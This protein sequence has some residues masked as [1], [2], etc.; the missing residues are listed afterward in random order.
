MK[1][2]LSFLL[3][4]V[5]IFSVLSPTTVLAENGPHPVPDGGWDTSSGVADTENYS[6]ILLF[7]SEGDI[8]SSLYPEDEEFP[9]DDSIKDNI[10]YDLS[11]NTLYLNGL[12]GKDFSLYLYDMGDDFKID[13]TGYNELLNISALNN[14]RGSSVA[15][16]G[17]G[18]L[19]LNRSGES[20][21][22][23]IAIV[24]NGS[25]DV[26]SIGESVKF[27]A[28]PYDDGEWQI[29]SV[30][31]I[32][33]T[34]ASPIVVNGEIT[35][36]EITEDKYVYD[37][38]KQYTV[39]DVANSAVNYY[40]AA[41][42]DEQDSKYDLYIAYEDYEN[43]GYVLYSIKYN[44]QIDLF[45]A[46]EYNEGNP[47]NPAE[48]GFTPAASLPLID[49]ETGFYVGN[50]E[51]YTDFDESVIIKDIFFDDSP[52]L[53]DICVDESGKE[54][55]YIAT[56]SFS[57][58]EANPVIRYTVYDLIQTEEFGFVARENPDIVS[59]EGF[60][61]VILNS[62]GRTD[63]YFSSESAINNGGN[64]TEPGVVKKITLTNN[65]DSIDVSFPAVKNAEY[66]D[67][68][69]YDFA[70]EEWIF[71]QTFK[72]VST[73][74]YKITD[75]TADTHYAFL[76]I[77]R[78]YVG[79]TLSPTQDSIAQITYRNPS[80]VYYEVN[81]SGIKVKW[82]RHKQGINY[83]VY[84]QEL[85]KTEWVKIA[86]TKN[87]NYTDKTAKYGVKYRYAV[88]T[89]F[90]KNDYTGIRTTPYI[91]RVAKTDVKKAANLS[92]GGVK[93]TWGKTAGADGYK[94]YRK[95]SKTSWKLLLNTKDISATSYIDK[96]AKNGTTYTYTVRAYNKFSSGTYESGVSIKALNAPKVTLANK[97]KGIYISWGKVSGASKY[98]VYRKL[99]G[100][101][102]W[103]AI[104]DTSSLSYTDTKAAAGKKY[105]YTVKALSGSYSSAYTAKSILRLKNPV[106]KAATKNENGV[107]L[108]WGKVAGAKGYNVYRKT[109]N[110]KW[111]LLGTVNDVVFTD[112]T[113]KKGVTYTYTI[114]AV[115]GKEIS[116]FYSSGKKIKA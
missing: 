82:Y 76:I 21:T 3:S 101:S 10:R 14:T 87:A 1:K 90:A 25:P 43:G 78:N 17:E 22:G 32:A 66:Y 49:E 27:K 42:I 93:V 59:F 26:L 11:S 116:G 58:D 73:P 12:I 30:S 5:L 13:L 89:F 112:V 75:V 84:R 8:S 20:F 39:H 114:R 54:Y 47:V 104:K 81:N 102:K 15:L 72:A 100:T 115:N 109:G 19:V 40:D 16:I 108:N 24:S 55:A 97:E 106:I 70:N 62:E 23:G 7:D 107:E 46:E 64:V 29:P 2:V 45:V 41:F 103:T 38:I 85:G 35:Q 74:K 80:K 88:R 94:I 95:T 77:A 105:D 65:A 50:P 6:A 96:T 60:S 69:V 113:A 83:R 36:G 86:D 53:M 52:L 79:S 99:S 37:Y 91:V 67:F 33:S 44:S 63:A 28:Y 71:S 56:E 31:V 110:S 92:G 18:E 68:F 34:A 9:V 111:S 61:P 98:R 4:L 48:L 51:E 57:E